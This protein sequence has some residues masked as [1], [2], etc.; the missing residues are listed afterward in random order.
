VHFAAFSAFSQQIRCQIEISGGNYFSR[1][2]PVPV[3]I[4]HTCCMLLTLKNNNQLRARAWMRNARN[5]NWIVMR[6]RKSAS[7]QKYKLPLIWIMWW[8]EINRR[9]YGAIYLLRELYF[10][11]FPCF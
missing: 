4:A 7:T 1:L 2:S 10:L 8:F 5:A 6:Q 11:M 9:F 3:I